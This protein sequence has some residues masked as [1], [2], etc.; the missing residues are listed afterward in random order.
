MTITADSAMVIA[1]HNPWPTT[2]RKLM[3]WFLQTCSDFLLAVN[4]TQSSSS[5]VAFADLQD[6]KLALGGDSQAYKRIVKKHQDHIARIM[7][8]F[9]RDS[10]AHEELVQDVFVEAYLSLRTYKAQAPLSHW[11]A[12]IASR[13]GY[14]YWKHQD[15]KQET[16]HFTLEEWDQLA[17][18]DDVDQIDPTAAANLLHKLLAQLPPRDRLVLTLHHL[19][20]CSVQETMQRTGWTKSMVKVQTWRAK[21]KLKKLLTEKHEDPEP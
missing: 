18:P 13:V 15:R 3:D 1:L 8:K 14:H 21:K 7:W 12:R 20:G 9:T 5:S 4:E 2:A 19:E 10:G 6:V 16:E 17:Q 11:L